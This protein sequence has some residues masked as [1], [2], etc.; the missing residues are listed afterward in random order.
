M[1]DALL[2][3][4]EDGVQPRRRRYSRE[5]KRQVVE[6]SLQPGASAAQVARAYELNGNLLHTWRWHYRSGLLGPVGHQGAALIPVALSAGPANERV[7][8]AAKQCL[9]IHCGELA[10]MLPADVDPVILRTV[11]TTLRT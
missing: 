8:V 4:G 2:A 6:Q 7:P 10:I 9:S 1:S 3:V 11:L 5:F